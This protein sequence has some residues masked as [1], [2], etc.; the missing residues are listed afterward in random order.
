MTNSNRLTKILFVGIVFLCVNSSSYGSVVVGY[1]PGWEGV[2]E[3]AV[4]EKLTHINFFAATVNADATLNLT[5][6]ENLLSMKTAAEAA[7]P[8][9]HTSISI[10][11]AS[12]SGNFSD[13]TADATK[14]ATLVSNIVTY[15]IDNDLDG[16]DLDWEGEKFFDRSTSTDA[17][18][19]TRF[20]H[21]LGDELHNKNKTL[22]IAVIAVIKKNWDT[23]KEPYEFLEYHPDESTNKTIDS[24]DLVNLMSYDMHYT[25]HASWSDTLEALLNWETDRNIPK[26]KIA[27]GLPFY[28]RGGSSDWTDF[29]AYYA[30]YEDIVA[31]YIEE[32]GAWPDDWSDC[33]NSVEVD[34]EDGDLPAFLGDP[35]IRDWGFNCAQLIADKTKYALDNGYAGVMIWEISQDLSSTDPHSL[36]GAIFSM[37]AIAVIDDFN[38]DA[39]SD[40]LIRNTSNNAWWYYPMDGNTVLAGGGS[41]QL[42]RNGDW[43]FAGTGD[44]NGDGHADVLVRNSVNNA[45]WYYPMNGSQVIAGGGSMPLPRVADWKF[46]GTG[47]FNGDGKDDILVRNSSN[48][49]WYYYPMDGNTLL[50]GGGSMLLTSNGDWR[51]ASIGDFNGDGKA[52]VLIRHDTNNAWWYYPMDGNTV[53]AGG[54]YVP[55]TRNGDWEP[56]NQ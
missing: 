13:V 26:S 42:T 21:E 8:S 56:V 48:N 11:G 32:N 10:G 40:I 29:G 39:K 55:L 47:D 27:I 22:S 45:W 24:L 51:L 28:G 7:N 50:A 23:A 2:Q 9:I 53:L 34:F 14:R 52:D 15:A 54:G 3:A 43:K 17:E 46:A 5:E 36:L 25:D 4:Y 41:M 33:N 44:F 20:I 6:L 19:Y 31:E 18:N 12:Q 30:S 1:S 16:V 49:A 37:Q 38:G 35:E